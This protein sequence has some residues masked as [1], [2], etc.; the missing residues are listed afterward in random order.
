MD[1]LQSFQLDLQYSRNSIVLFDWWNLY[2]DFNIC[3]L[4]LSYSESN[5]LEILK[6]IIAPNWEYVLIQRIELR[7]AAFC[8]DSQHV[9]LIGLCIIEWLI[10][11]PNWNVYFLNRPRE[12]YIFTKRNVWLAD[13][14]EKLGIIQKLILRLF[15]TFILMIAGRLLIWDLIAFLIVKFHFAH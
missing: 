3:S 4:S 9:R 6:S 5:L 11:E 12:Q 15:G 13:I 8:D 14:H 10:F 7:I 1:W 2:C